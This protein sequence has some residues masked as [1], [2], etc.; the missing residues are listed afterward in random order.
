MK[1]SYLSVALI[2]VGVFLIAFGLG[3]AVS[4]SD[5]KHRFVKVECA[6]GVAHT[7]VDMQTNGAARVVVDCKPEEKKQ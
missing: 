6:A 7:S 4:F 2:V 3:K 5:T 1:Y